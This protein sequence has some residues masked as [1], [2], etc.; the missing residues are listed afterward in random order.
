M[1]NYRHVSWSWNISVTQRLPTLKLQTYLVVVSFEIS[2]TK[3]KKKRR[4]MSTGKDIF[5]RSQYKEKISQWMGNID[6][7][8]ID[9]KTLDKLHKSEKLKYPQDGYPRSWCTVW[10]SWIQAHYGR[11]TFSLS[12]I[13]VLL[14]AQSCLISCKCS[15]GTVYSSAP[16]LVHTAE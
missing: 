13:Q 11:C 6:I 12:M 5:C 16:P 9:F 4:V 7:V 15:T 3:K 1:V 2:G 14:T 8:C 10:C